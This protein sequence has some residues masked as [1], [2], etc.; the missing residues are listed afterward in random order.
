MAHFILEYS[1]NLSEESVNVQALFAKMID[2]AMTTELFPLKGFRCRAYP[3]Q[4]YRMADGNPDHGFVH[5][6]MLVGP[7]RPL[8]ERERASD[9]LFTELKLHFA[10]EMKTRGLA[11]SFELKELTETTRFNHNNI[12][13]YL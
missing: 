1:T 6:S 13:E 3:C 8:A 10:T 12:G 7:G 5:L 4:H 2:T 11:L 9:L